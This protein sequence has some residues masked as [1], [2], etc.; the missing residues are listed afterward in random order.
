M[1]PKTKDQWDIKYGREMH[2]MPFGSLM[3]AYGQINQQKGVTIEAFVEDAL[4]IFVLAVEMADKSYDR[5][6][7]EDKVGEQ[8]EFPDKH[9]TGRDEN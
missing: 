9:E 6:E 2:F 5:S 7:Q 3:N 4:K 1:T 8:I